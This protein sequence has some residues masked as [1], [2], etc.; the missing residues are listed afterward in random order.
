MGNKVF[1]WL[2]RRLTDADI[3]DGQT[4][5]RAIRREVFETIE[6]RGD[7]TYTQE[8][9][10]KTAKEGWRIENVPVNFYQR[11]AGESRLISSP[12]LMHSV[13]GS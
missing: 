2:L 9:I 13:Q 12:Y 8:M 5:F 3:K 1:S 6:L 7:F 4:G 11:T 10:I